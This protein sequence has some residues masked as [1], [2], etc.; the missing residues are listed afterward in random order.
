VA[1]GAVTLG[2]FDRTQGRDLDSPH[3]RGEYW[4][5][6]ERAAEIYR[7]EKFGAPLICGAGE[8]RQEIQEVAQ[9][10][11]GMGNHNH[12]VRALPGVRLTDGRLRAGAAIWVPDATGTRS[13]LNNNAS[14]EVSRMRFDTSGRLTDFSMDRS[15]LG[16]W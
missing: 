14:G 4:R 3:K 12:H 5:P 8:T 10:I 11:R 6:L 15:E 1:L 2:L 13:H 7:T 9:N 16:H